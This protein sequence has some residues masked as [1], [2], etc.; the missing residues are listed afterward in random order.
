MI[1][2]SKEAVEM[3]LCLLA[4][5]LFL[6]PEIMCMQV[7]ELEIRRDD[8]IEMI[9]S[10]VNECYHDSYSDIDLCI[11]VSLSAEGGI[12]PGE[13]VKHVEHWGFPLEKILGIC[14]VPENSMY[15][16]ILKN[17]MRYD[18]GFA[19]VFQEDAPAIDLTPMSEQKSNAD[20]PV[21]NINRF[22]FIQIQALGKLYRNDFLIS[23][24]LA[25]M[26]L[27]ETLVQ[28]MVLR[29]LEYHTKHHRYGYKEELTHLKYTGKCPYRSGNTTFDHIADRIYSAALAYDELTSFFY[30]DYEPRSKDFFAIWKCYEE[31]RNAMETI[32]P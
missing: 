27:N 2:L 14:F 12:S 31:Q 18:L 3:N 25:N 32:I 19:F 13:Y 6:L 26:N 7:R 20:W 10:A 5:K 16:I 28:Q 22:W 1:A 21:E 9:R 15:R 4:D 23:S 8:R 17:G 11:V 24:H 29:D 30:D